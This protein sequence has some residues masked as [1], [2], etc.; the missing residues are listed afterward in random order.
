MP[1]VTKDDLM[2]V[3]VPLG[4]RVARRFDIELDRRIGFFPLAVRHSF[5]HGF[6]EGRWVR[7]TATSCSIPTVSAPF[8]AGSS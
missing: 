3:D 1:A 7:V 8:P 6:H 5:R 2:P 4:E